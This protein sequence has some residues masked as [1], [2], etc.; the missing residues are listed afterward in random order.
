MDDYG[1]GEAASL[2]GVSPDTVRRWIDSGKLVA[3]RTA[4]GRRRIDGDVLA[5]FVR[6]LHEK[7]DPTS[8]STASARNHLRGIVTKVVQNKIMAQ[9]DVQAGPFLLVALVTREAVDDLDLV[10][11]KMVYAVVKATNVSLQLADR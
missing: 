4:N 3:R 10:P 7:P 8:V 9:V 5:R 6:S 11:G 2:L 1:V